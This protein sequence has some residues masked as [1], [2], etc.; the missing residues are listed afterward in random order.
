M[1][2]QRL[3]RSDLRIE[4][5][6]QG[7]VLGE[8][9]VGDPVTNEENAWR[10]VNSDF[11]SMTIQR[12]VQV[13]KGVLFR[14]EASTL[15]LRTP[16]Q[17][18]MDGVFGKSIRV[19]WKNAL[20]FQGTV[21]SAKL[22]SSAEP[23]GDKTF[24]TITAVDNVDF[25]NQ[26]VL[27]NYSAPEQT[28][29]DRAVNA[30]SGTGI[31]MV[32]INCM[33]P[34]AARASTNI[35]LMTVLQE[36]S[37][38]QVAR[39]YSDRAG[40]LVMNGLRPGEPTITF[41]DV[42]EIANTL[43]Y[44]NINMDNNL[45]NTITGVVVVA[46]GDET[47]S[48]YRK[49]DSAIVTHE[50]VYEVDLPLAPEY[51]DAWIDSFPLRG[52]TLLEPSGLT[53]YWQDAMIDLDLTDL[54]AIQWKGRNYRSG[55]SGITYD[56]RPDEDYGLRWNVNVDLIPGHLI[57]F[58][59][60]VAPSPVRNFKAFATDPHTVELSWE[61][62]SMPAEQTGYMLRYADGPQAPVTPNDGILLGQFPLGTT[63]FTLTNQPSRDQNSYAIWAI[64]DNPNVYSGVMTTTAITPEVMPTAVRNLTIVKTRGTPQAGYVTSMT[65]TLDWDSPET[66]GDMKRTMIVYT[67]DGTAPSLNNGK[68]VFT[69]GSASQSIANIPVT[70]S[71]YNKT[72]KYAVYPETINGQYGPVVTTQLDTNEQIPASS[73]TSL[74]NVP[75][76]GYSP[77]LVRIKWQNVEASSVDFSTYRIEYNVNQAGPPNVPG[78]GTLLMQVTPATAI[79]Q[80][81]KISETQYQYEAWLPIG[82]NIKVA[83]FTQ[84][85]GGKYGYSWNAIQTP[86]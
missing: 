15:T 5:N 18:Y 71:D 13:E 85:L 23:N 14:P 50:E 41:S 45:T 11:N 29:G 77:R 84:T 4:T 61:R 44:R 56:I 33:R 49:H 79:N 82:S 20:L 58:S 67:L 60:I 59:S 64:T 1:S 65:H 21:R 16:S 76:P 74:E 2:V 51:L 78:S 34:L 37:D 39:F 70:F 9:L 52:Y 12:S 73:A 63:S 86:A 68:R 3:S 53:T 75:M 66:M 72:A 32:T 83:V 24:M 31:E 26:Y 27:Y 57:E 7:F 19:F 35:K 55:V 43:R 81:Y 36:A 28:V 69:A 46:K 40:R 10:N 38:A 8:S 54:V 17:E 47:L 80:G 22:S 6:D 62:P 25:A 42:P 48:M 30:T